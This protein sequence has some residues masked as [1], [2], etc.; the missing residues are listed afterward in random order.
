[1]TEITKLLA[2]SGIGIIQ[3]PCPEM[4]YYGI[5]RWGHVKDQF[6]NPYYRKHCRNI[7]RPFVEQLQDY[8]A[9]GYE[10]VGMLGI[11]GSPS[12]GVGMTCTGN[13][14]GEFSTN[15]DLKETL[16][17]VRMISESGVFMEEASALLAEQGIIV[18]FLGIDEAEMADSVI[19]IKNF[20]RGSY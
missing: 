7:F 13:W 18:P 20:I 5:K 11:E 3:L 1:M 14:G 19:K 12:C 2:D 6:D 15:P 4:T 8:A 17:T 16:D 9:N 10:I